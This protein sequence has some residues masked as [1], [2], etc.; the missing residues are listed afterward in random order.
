MQC[1]EVR[2]VIRGYQRRNILH[3]QLQRMNM[4][5]SMFC[6]GNPNHKQPQDV[7]PL[8][9]DDWDEDSDLPTEDEIADVVAEINAV[10]GIKQ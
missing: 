5:A 7:L 2:R 4:W 10:N 9:F 6:M 8:Y 1:W 3:Y